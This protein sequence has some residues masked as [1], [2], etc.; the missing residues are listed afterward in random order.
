MKQVLIFLS[1]ALVLF[2]VESVSAQQPLDYATAYK[3]AQSGDKPLLVLVTAKWCPPCQAMKKNTIPELLKKS[4]FEGYHYTNVDL[5]KDSKVARQL[6]GSRGVP[7]LILFEKKSGKW[8]RKFLSG[9]NSVASV[10]KFVMKPAVRTA[11]L[12]TPAVEKK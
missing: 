5:D 3:N 4:A 6:I 8:T 10:E 2:A 12:V 7:Q 9:Y 11:D 1:A